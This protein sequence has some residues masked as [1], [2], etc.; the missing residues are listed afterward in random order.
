MD[1]NH[2]ANLVE[3]LLEKKYF[4]DHYDLEITRRRKY[5][6]DNEEKTN[7]YNK[8]KRE[9]DLYFKLVCNL[10]SRTSSAIKSKNNKKMNK[11]FD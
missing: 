10:R 3:N 6:V 8:K 1:Y 11:T 5:R 4:D 2:I 7:D 9:S